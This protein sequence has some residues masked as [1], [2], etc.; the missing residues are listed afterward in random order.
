[1]STVFAIDLGD[2]SMRI[3]HWKE[4]SLKEI[5]SSA[6]VIVNDYQKTCSPLRR[7]M[8]ITRSVSLVLKRGSVLVSSHGVI[9]V[10]FV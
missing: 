2:T 5:A 1:M 8:I 9:N 10:S 4:S 7:I 3:A 6:D